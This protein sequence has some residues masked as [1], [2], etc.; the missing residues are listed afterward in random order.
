ML[1]VKGEFPD[2]LC[3]PPKVSYPIPTLG[4]SEVQGSL[5]IT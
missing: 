3:A 2:D 4:L 1:R 5:E